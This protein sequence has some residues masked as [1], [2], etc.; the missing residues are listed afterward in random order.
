MATLE[1]ALAGAIATIQREPS[2]T[3]T[4]LANLMGGN[5]ALAMALANTSNKKSAAYK[6]QLRNIQR[7][8]KR[9]AQAEGQG[10]TPRKYSKDIERIAEREAKRSTSDEV[11]RRGV[12]VTYDGRIIV[13]PGSKK[14]DDRPDRYIRGVFIRGEWMAPVMDA[15]A[16]GDWTTAA[17][18]FQEAFL[19][20]WAGLQ[21]A[22]MPEVNDMPMTIGWH[23]VNYSDA[24]ALT[25]HA[26]IAR[27]RNAVNKLE[28]R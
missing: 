20:E 12:T 18:A 1:A 6:S 19:A 22:I 15:V 8:R 23:N 2:T 21:N 5:P 9:E 27:A 25:T 24:G 11:K 7:Y 17:D 14:Q 13:S 16:A 3:V 4:D 28:G 10:R 26:A